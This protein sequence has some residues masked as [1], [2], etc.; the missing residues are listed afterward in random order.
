MGTHV[1]A[2]IGAEGF[3][4]VLTLHPLPLIFCH[5]CPTLLAFARMEVSIE[6]G[7]IGAILV[8]YL[9]GFDVRM[10]DGYCF[11]L[12][13]GDAVEPRSQSEDAVDD[14]IEL[15]VGS[16]HLCIDVVFLHLQLMRIESHVPRFQ[17]LS[18]LR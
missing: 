18:I 9:I 3:L 2:V 4:K 13:E 8:K 1:L 10:V 17:S 6:N 7:Q 11:V 12:L 14:L 5:P 15:E 16:Q